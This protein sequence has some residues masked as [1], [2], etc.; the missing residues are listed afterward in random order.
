MT[1]HSDTPRNL[2]LSDS[3]PSDLED[4]M[5]D[6]FPQDCP[7]FFPCPFCHLPLSDQVNSSLAPPQV[8]RRLHLLNSLSNLCLCYSPGNKD[9]YKNR[10]R[11]SRSSPVEPELC[12]AKSRSSLDS[13][14]RLDACRIVNIPYRLSERNSPEQGR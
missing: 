2:V 11:S 6:H 7:F 5:C 1:V 14:P 8:S 9:L 13:H 3:P 12:P 4:L 10:F